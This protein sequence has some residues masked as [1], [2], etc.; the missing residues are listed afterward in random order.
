MH[1]NFIL[2]KNIF[3]HQNYKNFQD[4]KKNSKWKI[5]IQSIFGQHKILYKKI[6]KNLDFEI[7]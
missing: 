2:K 4:S 6:K 7:L 1:E 5:N 3:F